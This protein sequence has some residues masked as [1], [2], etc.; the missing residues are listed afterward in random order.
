M[1]EYGVKEVHLIIKDVGMN[2]V[3]VLSSNISYAPYDI[4]LDKKTN[5]IDSL[6]FKISP[7]NDKYMYLFN[8]NI[9]EYEG[10]NYII[11]SSQLSSESSVDYEIKAEHESCVLKKKM[12]GA[13][14]MFSNTVG[15]MVESVL[16]GTGF[17]FGGTDIEDSKKRHLISNEE[18]VFTNLNSIAEVFDARLKIETKTVNGVIYKSVS[19]YEG[20]TNK[21]RYFK[22][23]RDLKSSRIGYSTENQITKLH[24]FGG[25][26]KITGLEID[27]IEA[28][29]EH[30]AYV[31]DYSYF[32]D[33]G[34]TKI[35][36]ASCR[37]RV[38]VL[39]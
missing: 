34:L 2:V 26:D 36:R 8:E 27:M 1:N 3:G 10:E 18:S 4:K 14:E 9:V 32:L 38:Y 33:Q 21:G 7:L 20:S 25:T 39:V 24:V 28:H 30:K 31:E 6:S 37:E 17:V 13:I 11:N 15:E 35:G 12:N 5:E 23:G 22:R 29:P 19:V 16:E